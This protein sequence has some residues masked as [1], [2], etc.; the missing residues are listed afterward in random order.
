MRGLGIESAFTFDPH[1]RERGFQVVPEDQ[2]IA[3]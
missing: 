3:T 2:G 1:F